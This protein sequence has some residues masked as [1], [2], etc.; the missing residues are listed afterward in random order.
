MITR[1]VITRPSLMSLGVPSHVHLDG[2]VTVGYGSSGLFTIQFD[3]YQCKDRWTKRGGELRLFQ[4]LKQSKAT[5]T[6]AM[7]V[8]AP[9][10]QPD[11]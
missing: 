9:I 7:L 11:N 6:Y 3:I 5:L 1:Q 10:H 4:F 2:Q 8:V